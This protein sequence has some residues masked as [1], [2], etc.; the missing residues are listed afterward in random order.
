MR[1][2]PTPAPQPA[3]APWAPA[4]TW[5]KFEREIRRLRAMFPKTR[6]FLY[7]ELF[8]AALGPAAAPRPASYSPALLAEPIPGPLTDRLAALAVE[9]DA[10]LRPGPFSERG[11]DR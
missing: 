5:Q 3:P 7:P 4:A 9:L 8:L 1:P 10:W 11:A 6:L 2:L